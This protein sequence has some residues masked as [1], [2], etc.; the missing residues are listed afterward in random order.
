MILQ[1]SL[2]E[3]SRK[4]RLFYRENYLPTV[5]RIRDVYHRSR[6]LI[7][8]QPGSRIEQKRGG[9][10]FHNIENPLNLIF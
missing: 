3:K 7:F 9:H 2:Q 8:V 5:L 10:K 6:T 4:I 1:N